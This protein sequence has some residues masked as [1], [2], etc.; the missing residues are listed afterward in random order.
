MSWM[1]RALNPSGGQIF[2]THPDQPSGLPIRMYNEYQ[3]SL[4][5]VKQP[6]RGIDRPHP[7]I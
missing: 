6:G 1:V 3:V 2:R 4:P 5:G 7:P